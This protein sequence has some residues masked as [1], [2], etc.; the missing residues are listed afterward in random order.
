MWQVVVKHIGRSQ[1]FT[2]TTAWMKHQHTDVVRSL[3][4]AEISAVLA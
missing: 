1:L 3:V 4:G 2:V